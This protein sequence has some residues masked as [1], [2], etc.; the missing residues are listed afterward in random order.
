MERIDRRF[1][2]WKIELLAGRVDLITAARAGE[3]LGL[4]HS[5]SA[6]R[7]DIANEFSNC[8]Y[9]EE[10][11]VEPF[12]L[13]VAK[14]NPD[15]SNDIALAV[16]ASREPGVALV[17]GDYSPKNLL[18]DGGDVVILDLEI[19]HFGNPRFDVAFMLS[20]LI[21]KGLRRGV[22]SEAYANAAKIFI[23]AYRKVGI[24]SMF[25]AAL[26]RILGCL[27]LARFEGA[28]PVDYRE[29]IDATCVKKI[30]TEW[31]RRPVVDIANA[32]NRALEI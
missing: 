14:R 32:V 12:F 15:L 23:D 28:S 24:T 17:H 3:L 31:I 19:A 20:H 29:Q 9:F 30:A 25:D 4:L 22:D 13:R 7:A 2:N 6:T 8:A 16:A 11:R 18:V 10:L 27:L 26:T 5:R 1:K 21:L